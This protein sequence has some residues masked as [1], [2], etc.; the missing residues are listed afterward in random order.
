MLP[1]ITRQHSHYHGRPAVSI[2][3]P[4]EPCFLETRVTGDYLRAF[5]PAGVS[6]QCFQAILDI[7][8]HRHMA[9]AAC[10]EQRSPASRS[11]KSKG[12][13]DEALVPKTR[14][15]GPWKREG[16]FVFTSDVLS[17]HTC[18]F[19]QVLNGLK[20]ATPRRNETC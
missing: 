9:L 17:D 7:L 8:W 16:V 12:V 11:P 18:F 10:Q 19:P 1:H 3:V 13:T 2:A 15:P 20:L 6:P 14:S 5:S 4:S